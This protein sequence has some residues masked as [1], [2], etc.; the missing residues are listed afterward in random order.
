MD[1]RIIQSIQIERDKQERMWGDDRRHSVGDW[2]RI[3]KREAS[4]IE[5][6]A[7]TDDVDRALVKVAAVAIAALTARGAARRLEVH[8]EA[9]RRGDPPRKLEV[10]NG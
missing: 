9:W 3:L 4:A 1:H 5:D 6:R 2:R 7:C 8:N 10:H